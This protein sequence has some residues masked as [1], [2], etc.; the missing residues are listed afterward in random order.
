ML[1]PNE[2][3]LPISLFLPP[4]NST[5]SQ[6]CWS[7]IEFGGWNWPLADSPNSTKMIISKSSYPNIQCTNQWCN[8][9]LRGKWQ[10]QVVTTDGTDDQCSF[11]FHHD[12]HVFPARHAPAHTHTCMHTR[13]RAHTDAV[14]PRR[15][16]KRNRLDRL[17]RTLVPRSTIPTCVCSVH[18][19]HGFT[20]QRKPQ[21][22]HSD[23]GV[24]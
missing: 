22:I 20:A 6:K 3:S 2:L 4:F 5:L 16:L 19:A 8:T 23:D 15:L 11:W 17:K 7:S 21:N 24:K 14:I 9:Y 13:T 18:F 1:I 10:H 12:I